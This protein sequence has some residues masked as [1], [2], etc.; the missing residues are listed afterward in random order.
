LSLADKNTYKA[1]YTEVIKRFVYDV[2][3]N[4]D[5]GPLSVGAALSL[6]CGTKH[7]GDSIRNTVSRGS[8]EGAEPGYWWTEKELA[9][10]AEELGAQIYVWNPGYPDAM[11]FSVFT[12]TIKSIK[13]HENLPLRLFIIGGGPNNPHYRPLLASNDLTKTLSDLGFAARLVGPALDARPDNSSA[14]PTPALDATSDN[15]SAASTPALDARRDNSSAAPTPSLSGAPSAP[16]PNPAAAG[17][18]AALAAPP[19]AG[20]PNPPP[21]GAVVPPVPPPN[22]KAGAKP[23]APPAGAINKPVELHQLVKECLLKASGPIDFS[24]LRNIPTDAND[25]ELAKQGVIHLSQFLRLNPEVFPETLVSQIATTTIIMGEEKSGKTALVA[26]VLGVILAYS[27]GRV[28]TRCPTHYTVSHDPSIAPSEQGGPRDGV[29]ITMTDPRTKQSE[30]FESLFD[31]HKKATEIQQGIVGVGN[32]LRDTPSLVDTRS[33]RQLHAL[34]ALQ[35]TDTPGLVG[36]NAGQSFASGVEKICRHLFHTW[37]GPPTS[38]SWAVF[39]MRC[40]QQ[41]RLQQWTNVLSGAHES[42]LSRVAIVLTRID[43]LTADVVVNQ[44]QSYG[45]PLSDEGLLSFFTTEIR[46]QI[47]KARVFLVANADTQ[48]IHTEDDMTKAMANI[49]A[50]MSQAEGSR[51]SKFLKMLE[52]L[53]SHHGYTRSPTAYNTLLAMT[54]I[55]VF[56]QFIEENSQQGT[57]RL[58]EFVAQVVQKRMEAIRKELKE[59]KVEYAK[60]QKTGG[61]SEDFVRKILSSTN[62][63]FYYLMTGTNIPTPSDMPANTDSDLLARDVWRKL[64]DSRT[65]TLRQETLSS[66]FPSTMDD[67]TLELLYT[68]VDSMDAPYAHIQP[69]LNRVFLQFILR[70][71]LI[72]PPK[73]TRTDVFKFMGKAPALQ[74]L[75]YDEFIEAEIQT[76][77]KKQLAD[78]ASS[79]ISDACRHIATHAVE[80]TLMGIKLLPQ[81]TMFTSNSSDSPE[82]IESMKLFCEDIKAFLTQA[83]VER[84]AGHVRFES[85]MAAAGVET[86]VVPFAPRLVGIAPVLLPRNKTYFENFM[87]HR[88]YLSTTVSNLGSI[89]HKAV[90]ALNLFYSSM[91]GYHKLTVMLALKKNLT[92]QRYIRACWHWKPNLSHGIKASKVG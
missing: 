83:W 13:F 41:V 68:T 92:H 69:R 54:G 70:I 75:S 20:V 90:N 6:L 66:N 81:W 65:A 45:L 40:Q 31:A 16:N 88:G 53:P 67:Q 33:R 38:T 8:P 86:P 23:P 59:V 63:L 48:N 17:G 4:G 36:A 25:P 1:A 21:A 74:A 84:L 24:P 91:E 9:V 30:T 44:L 57:A 43:E 11:S 5:C 39:V 37:V 49:D 58:S 50:E 29:V 60:I 42:A 28:A 22:E 72:S 76:F 26:G 18:A 32:G 7:T 2:G 77:I 34:H 79:H 55:K 62:S 71:L 56:R 10:A 87:G 51:T 15:S 14:A 52:S 61:K 12:P 80:T 35:T 82:H 78:E 89:L 47:P 3:G 73:V 27:E 19:A 46:N 85:Q 64:L